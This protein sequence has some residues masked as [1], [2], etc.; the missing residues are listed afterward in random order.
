M[1][2]KSEVPPV[3]AGNGELP[4]GDV[5]AEASRPQQPASMGRIEGVE[6]LR[7]DPSILKKTA[8]KLLTT[9]PVKKPHRQEFIRVHPDGDKRMLAALITLEED[10]E[11]FLVLPTFVPEVDPQFYT[12]ATLFLTINRSKV[13]Y[14]WPVKTPGQNGK[15]LEWHT[16][17]LAGAEHAMKCWTRIASNMDLGAYEI[18]EAASQIGEPEWPEVSFDE[19]LRIAFRDKIIRGHDHPAMKKLNGEL[20]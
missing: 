17:A 15:T 4:K 8:K 7:L 3:H 6:S 14:L 11:T 19:I 2:S 1:K 10:R 16:S 5:A 13:V 18:F 9:V 20:I 12:I